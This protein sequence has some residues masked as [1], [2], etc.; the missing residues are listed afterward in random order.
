MP[1]RVKTNRRMRKKAVQQGLSEVRERRQMSVTADG[2]ESVS[3][4]CLRG[5]SHIL[6]LTHPLRACQD[7]RLSRGGTGSL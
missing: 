3:A 4:R 1:S 7:R 5:E 2:R 6:P